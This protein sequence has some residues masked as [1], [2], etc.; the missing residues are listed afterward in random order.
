[1]THLHRGRV[2]WFSSISIVIHPVIEIL[3]FGIEPLWHFLSMYADSDVPELLLLVLDH[4]FFPFHGQIFH[5]F[6]FHRSMLLNT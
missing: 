5:S 1:L 2:L 6:S 3:S 4:F